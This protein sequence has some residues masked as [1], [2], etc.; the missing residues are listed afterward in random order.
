VKGIYLAIYSSGN[1][2]AVTMSLPESDFYNVISLGRLMQG[3]MVTD[4]KGFA[5]SIGNKSATK[6][7]MRDAM[8]WCAI[9]FLDHSPI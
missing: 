2:G 7:G 8:H 6:S 3:Y 1:A 9:F 5:S 4:P